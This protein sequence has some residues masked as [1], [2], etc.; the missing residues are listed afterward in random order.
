MPSDVKHHTHCDA[1][2]AGFLEGD[3]NSVRMV[4]QDHPLPVSQPQSRGVFGEQIVGQLDPVI[5]LDASYGLRSTTDVEVLSAAGGSAT[6]ADGLWDCATG[7]SV[8]GYGVLRSRRVVRYKAGLGVRFRFTAAFDSDNATA[9]SLQWAGVFSAVD[10]VGFGYNGTSFGLNRRAPGKIGVYE[11]DITTGTGGAGETITITLDG[12][13]FPVAVGSGLTTAEVASA[14]AAETYTGWLAEATGSEVYFYQ[15]NPAAFTGAFSF[16]ST[17][18]AAATVTQRVAGAANDN[19]SGHVA[20]TS[21]DRQPFTGFD[22]SNLNAY[23]VLIGY[24]GAANFT[25]RVYDPTRSVYQTVHT[26]SFSDTDGYTGPNLN[27]P[28][29]RVGYIA[30]SLGS[31][32]DLHVYGAS[33]LGA[34]EGFSRPSRNPQAWSSSAGSVTTEQNLLS[35][36][37]GDIFNRVVNRQEI[38]PLR[39]SFAVGSGK[40]AEVRVYLNGAVTGGAWSYVEENV[41]HAHY[42]ETGGAVTGGRL[43]AAA[44]IPGGGSTQINLSDFGIRLS[45]GDTLNLTAFVSG[46]AGSDVSASL[47]WQE[48]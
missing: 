5:Q 38:L 41:S 22:P 14:L 27:D 1:I 32:T 34:R 21:W 25:F 36:R 30:A 8:G 19:D 46:G 20:Q 4:S 17:G 43:V 45:P 47:T 2:R 44:A 29:L 7:T 9:L 37:N 39:A 31:T 18:T 42:D 12:T 40:P 16:A 10:F 15:T 26:V 35:V 23:E 6:A 28:S 33:M 13:A 11:F 24:L 3:V 48:D